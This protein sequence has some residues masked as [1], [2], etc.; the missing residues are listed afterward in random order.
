MTEGQQELPIGDPRMQAVLEQL[1]SHAADLDA[2]AR[3]LRNLRRRL[4]E[5]A[6]VEVASPLVYRPA[7]TPRWWEMQP[8]EAAEFID[9]IREW[10]ETV[11]KRFYGH[12]AR[13]MG[14][15]YLDHPMAIL[16][17]DCLKETWRTLFL[18]AHRSSGIARGQ[19]EFH[20]H[21][22][23]PLARLLNQECL[24]NCER[25]GKPIDI[26]ADDAEERAS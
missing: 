5:V 26:P 20:V 18:S 17:L 16:I 9:D 19:N 8:G 15:C 25:H 12:L 4:D 14:D 24:R 6:P 21:I 22:L 23:I 2:L 3:A 13:D 1:A 7:P 10:V 11:Y